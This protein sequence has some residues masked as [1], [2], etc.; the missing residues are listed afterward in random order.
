[1]YFFVNGVAGPVQEVLAVTRI[2]DGFAG[3]IVNLP[4]VKNLTGRIPLFGGL[5][6]CITPITN[7]IENFLVFGRHAVTNEKG[8]RDV[9]VD[10]VRHS[11]LRPHIDQ[12]KL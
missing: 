6:R 9:V 5:Y 7:D 1:M 2:R 8:P 11:P 12:A 10:R 4:S 3:L